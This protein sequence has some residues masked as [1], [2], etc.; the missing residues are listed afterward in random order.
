ME[1]FISAILGLG[2]IFY[3]YQC[4]RLP[5]NPL[6]YFPGRLKERKLAFAVGL[7]IVITGF[8]ASWFIGKHAELISLTGTWVMLLGSSYWFHQRTLRRVFAPSEWKII[9]IT[10]FSGLII[11]LF[12]TGIP[13]IPARLFPGTVFM[14][15]AL[16]L[17][18]GRLWW[19]SNP[20]QQS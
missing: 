6:D 13:G 20:H 16:I 2:G 9:R 5:V 3:A 7:V 17:L 12:S 18:S 10:L 8:A 4:P 19:L 1:S 14:G 11:C 15:I